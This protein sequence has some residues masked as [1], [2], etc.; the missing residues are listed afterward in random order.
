M[1]ALPEALQLRRFRRPLTWLTWRR[2]FIIAI[3]ASVLALQALGAYLDS[4]RLTITRSAAI[5][6][7]VD[8]MV[9]R[10]GDSGRGIG[11]QVGDYIRE[12]GGQ[13]VE[14]IM[15]YRRAIDRLEEG[16]QVVVGVQRPEGLVRLAPIQV[17]NIPLDNSL[18]LRHVAGLTFWVVATWVA[19]VRPQNRVALLF[20]LTSLGMA[21]YFALSRTTVEGLIYAHSVALAFAPALAIHFFLVFPRETR[22]ASSPWVALLYVPSFVLAVLTIRAYAA[23]VEAG[24]GLYYAPAYQFLSSR[25]DLSYLAASA[26]FGFAMICHTYRTAARPI[27]KRRLQWIMLGLVFAILVAVVDITLSVLHRHTP[28]VT[29]W[30]FLGVLPLPLSFA[31]AVL[32]YRLWDMDIVLSRS[33]VYGVLTAGLAAFYLLLISL[34]SNALGVAAGSSQYTLV[35]FVSALLIGILVN[36]SRAWLQGLI[37]RFFFRQQLDYQRALARWSEDLSTSLRFT[38]LAQL[39]LCRVP[40]QFQITQARLLVLSE[41]ERSFDPLD[42]AT[43][44]A[45]NAGAPEEL[46][47]LAHSA[48][49][50]QLARTASVV[51]PEGGAAN[52][53]EMAGAT[54]ESWQRR[55]VSVV[56]PLVSGGKLVGIY[57]LGPKRSGDLYQTRELELLRTLSNQ[58]AVAIANA[59]LY[60]QVHSLS[61]ELEIKVKGRTKELRHFLSAV[62]HELSTPMTSIR[63]Y[64]SVLLDGKAGPLTERQARYLNAVRRNVRRL[65]RL[66]SDLADV[67]SIEDGRLTIQ[68]EPLDLASLVTESLDAFSEVI[69]EKG[70]Q[71][72]LSIAPDASTVLGDPQRLLQILSNLLSNACRYTPAGGQITISA[73]CLGK[74]AELVVRDTGI[75]IHKDDL[76]H[77][78]DRFYRSA[79]PLVQEQPGTGLGLAITKSLVELHGSQL[80]VTSTRG[81]GSAFGFTL[82]LAPGPR[83]S[84]ATESSGVTLAS[85]QGERGQQ[86]SSEEEGHG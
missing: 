70:L 71:V 73:T 38:D 40:E 23:A 6:L 50:I 5:G 67:S 14:T 59:R 35:L 28:A 83:R 25:I 21:L 8:L 81:E 61:Q 47:V 17:A 36:P 3:A 78:F 32:R 65:M 46:S 63:G 15:D 30:L 62:Y 13:P 1:N 68:A 55:G 60:E 84:Q 39:L 12:L 45:G 34:L 85:W 37:D 19:L 80:W 66:V 77:I 11:F 31:F 69:E 49:A 20:F 43:R 53:A 18:I 48:V 76:E 9:T 41:D 29:V 7:D 42:P 44:Q 51:L 82:P 56:L 16:A 26:V 86:H 33:A 10:V 22:L 24:A 75:G 2:V 27:Q 72:R 79:D 52:L 54:L 4:H 58:A 64:T 57:L 74:Q